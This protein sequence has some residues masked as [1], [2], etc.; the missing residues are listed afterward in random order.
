MPKAKYER[1]RLPNGKEEYVHRIK[2][3]AKKGEVVHHKDS[4]GKNN[5]KT[6]LKKMTRGK[7]VALS[8]KRRA[9]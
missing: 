7:N 8:N 2:A 6:N 4:N 5:A 1:K 9:K 3:K